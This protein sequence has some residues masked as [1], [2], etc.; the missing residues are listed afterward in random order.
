LTRKLKPQR[1]DV[2]LGGF[3]V[4]EPLACP[5]CGAGL[6][7]DAPGG[8]CPRCLMGAA[9]VEED[10]EP[11]SD[12]SEAPRPAVPTDLGR[13]KRAV[14][15]LGLIRDEE[16]ERFVAGALGGV[17]GLA[18][19]LVRA[20]KLTPYQ[21]AALTQGKARGLVIG[22]YFVLDKLGAG[23]M[24]VVFKARHRRLGRVVALKILPPSLARNPDLFLRFRREV[25]VAARLSHPNIVPV[26]DADEDRGVPFMTMEYIQGND[27]DRLVR[28]G[29]VLPVDLALD[30][31]IQ[32]ARGLEA[33]HSQGIVHRDIK[34]GNLMLDGSGRVRVLDLGLA[35]LIEAS[36]PFGETG[37]GALTKSGTY[38]G[39]VDFMAPEQGIDSSR[40]DH[41]ADIY[42]LACTLCYLLTGRAPFEG[43]NVLSRL[44]AHQDQVP[45]SLLTRRPEVPRAIDSTYREMMAKK[46]ADRPASMGEVI[47]R[48]EACRSSA[49]QADEARSGLQQF[50]ETV[51]L[52]RAL[53]R[54]SNPGTS[55]FAREVPTEVEYAP[56]RNFEDLVLD[57]REE[58]RPAP[59]V[60][61]TVVMKPEPASEWQGETRPRD[62]NGLILPFLALAVV[63]LLMMGGM[64]FFF[65]SRN[66]AR[67]QVVVGPPARQ[68]RAVPRL[69][70]TFDVVT[71]YSPHGVDGLES[72][73]DTIAVPA[74]GK[75]ALIGSWTEHAELVNLGEARAAKLIL[76]SDNFQGGWPVSAA[77]TPDGTRAMVGTLSVI[78]ENLKRASAK[79]AGIVRFWDMTTGREFLPKQ[80]PYDG[81]VFAVAISRDGQRG[82][83]ASRKGELTVW[84][85]STGEPL[86]SLGP[87]KGAISPRALA[88][89][90]DGRR[91]A[92]AGHDQLVH[93]W[94]LESGS[95]EA[96]WKGHI[97]AVAG[98]A[99]SADGRRIA[100][101]GEDGRVN[102]WDVAT[103][104]VLHRF[105]MPPNDTGAR[106]AFDSDGNLV[107]A[108]YG[109]EG[110]PSKPGNLIVWDAKTYAELR[111]N[112]KPFA[113]HLALAVLPGGQL[114]TGD[115]YALR[116]WTPR[117]PVADSNKP[118]AVANQDK[119][120]VDLL[121]LIQPITHN[122]LG[123]WRKDNDGALVSPTNG[124]SRLR[125]PHDLPPEYQIEM[126]V[127]RVG[128]GNQRAFGLFF[129]V[130]D[131]QTYIIFDKPL[132]KD[133]PCSGL[134]GL[135]GIPVALA[136]KTHRG[137]VIPAS[138]RVRLSLS[139]GR[140]SI[141]MSCD[142]S[143]VVDWT[144]DPKRLIRSLTWRVPDSKE[145]L[146][147][148][149]G[150]SYLIREITLIPSKAASP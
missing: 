111:R 14:L 119:S 116:L 18:R 70:S 67:T 58:A 46:P 76:G 10:L 88:I 49:G 73:V 93:I 71:L 140:N 91:A 33:V 150:G 12:A 54:G 104:K 118:P 3:S 103:G 120:P 24:G 57:Y 138:R 122:L 50:A 32:A 148:T 36:N 5:E 23:G 77:I 144:G 56:D 55:V 123:E 86:H 146:L 48:L 121:S 39:T 85:L 30:C 69:S 127:E 27:L 72:S 28:D 142:G 31:V 41:R 110:P 83:S 2:P 35:R 13:F 16:F 80:Q 8:L 11:G 64:G 145:L 102:L 89:F 125:V 87:H 108:G 4:N 113:R 149:A 81:D 98:L 84:D 59:P 128:Q 6:P 26:L 61:P 43:S 62:G 22:N 37:V 99:I 94:N 132:Q 66:S 90:P 78:E 100:T 95:E 117:P 15:E 19:A 75:H 133:G 1:V 74:D 65:Y 42:S 97:K 141:K 53:P 68:P 130:G 143:S 79:R 134:D 45:A 52:K 7:A 82:I 34:P 112:E 51:L 29:G 9:V 105:E 25:D 129:V 20:G 38:M 137:Q 131:R 136:P 40:V 47:R 114:L 21:A 44:M 96:T 17:Q 115:R 92:S 126:E 101:G 106:V 107:A 124:W 139:V 60:A 147:G 109:L 135:D 63:A